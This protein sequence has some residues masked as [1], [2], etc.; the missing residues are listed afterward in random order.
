MLELWKR[1]LVREIEKAERLEAQALETLTKHES[2]L[3]REKLK[4]ANR[5]LE[6]GR[7][8]LRIVRFGNG[9][10]NA[11]YSISLLDLAN[12]SFKNTI[13]YLEGKDMSEG[14]RREE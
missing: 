13:G 3:T 8:N 2:K 9:V 14:I 6:L 12:A 11:K 7:D 5:M 1:E 4:E 10:H